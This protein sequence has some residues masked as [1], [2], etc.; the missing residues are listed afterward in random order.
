[1]NAD[2]STIVQEEHFNLWLAA[3]DEALA[4]G[5][6]EAASYAA[7]APAALRRRLER[8]LSW[9]QLVRRLLPRDDDATQVH[10]PTA[11]PAI[12]PSMSRLGRFHIRRELGRGGFGVVFLA[13]DPDLGRDVALK[14]PRPEAL[15]SADLRA[16]FRQEARVAANL[17]HPAIVAVHEAGEED[18]V[19][20]IASAYCPGINLAAWLRQRSEPVTPD[21]AA[22]LTA[23]LA[24]AVA[25]AHQRGILH[26]DLKPAN[27]LLSFS[28]ERPAG[29]SPDA[30]AERSRLNEYT[31]RITDFGLAKLV[32]DPS[33]TPAEDGQTHSGAVLGTPAY[34][35]PEQAGGRTRTAGPAADV[36]ALGVILYELLTGRPPFQG[37][38]P[39]DT[40]LLVRTTEPLSPA[41]LR[42]RLPRDLET[43]CLKCLHKDPGGRYAGAADLAA[44]LNRFLRREPIRARPASVW[45]RGVKWA[46][47]RPAAAALAAVSTAAAAAVIVVVLIANARLQHERD[48]AESRRLEAETQRQRALTHLREAR[49]TADRFLTRVG[50][51]QLD[52]VPHMETVR[53]ELLED[54]VR[55][56]ENFARLES[57]DPEIR[58]ETGRAWRRLGKIHGY[59]GNRDAAEQSY[60]AAVAVHEPLATTFPDRPEYRRELAASLNNLATVLGRRNKASEQRQVLEQAVSLQEGLAADFPDQADYRQD[61]GQSYDLQGQVLAEAGQTTEAEQAFRRAADVLDGVVADAPSILAYRQSQAIC[62]RNLGVLLAKQDRFA[63]AVPFFEKDL[64]FWDRLA[65]E[66]P[67]VP[68]NRGRAS[69][70]AYH[71]GNLLTA[72]GRPEDGKKLLARSVA[73]R[74]SLAE[75]FPRVPA[76]HV[77]LAA[78]Q[79]KLARQLRQRGDFAGARPLLEGAVAHLRSAIAI[80]PVAASRDLVSSL[81]WLLADTQLQLGEYRQ[82]AVV[83]HELPAI[84]PAHWEE[85]YQAARLLTR[86]VPAARQDASLD[87]ARSRELVEQ[88]SRRAV[89]LLREAGRRGHTD[90]AYMKTDTGLDVLRARDDFKELM[91]EVD[92]PAR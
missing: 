45:E 49:E 6:V 57:D 61:L 77:D 28:G 91:R 11:A 21:D 54:A 36:Y 12:L 51:E 89:D 66:H 16:R 14:V 47:R 10:A 76:Y 56:Y 52:G 67:E 65:E 37:D 31:P 75:E 2:D 63:E 78:A 20:Y 30:L 18:G 72:T 82:A 55:S 85:C 17:D 29:A 64:E 19:C 15:A 48:L 50:F 22:R 86:C 88:Y 24:E 3:G 32:G 79:E 90:R 35:A 39:L 46:R 1:M 43:I 81:S 41:R 42:P 9:C 27:I 73:R 8:E 5:T 69:D 7:E 84:R 13:H 83:A 44:D 40:L 68:R 74:Q 70:A 34:M 71:L 92:G 59:L 60:R 53:R 58:W 80:D 25:H 26:R 62:K 33:T 23:V 38:T 87:E 4:A